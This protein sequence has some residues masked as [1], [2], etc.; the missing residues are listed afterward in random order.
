MHQA[1]GL[2]YYLY[3][4]YDASSQ[5]WLNR[6]PLQ[7]RGGLNLYSLVRNAPISWFDANGL[8]DDSTI[9]CKGGKYDIVLGWAK[10][11]PYE[12]C[13]RAHEESHIK[14]WKKRYG[15]NS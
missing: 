2:I 15:E 13:V 6:D 3:R 10:G 14:D 4:Y 7:E 9:Q 12:A 11:K 8:E 5:R 1:S